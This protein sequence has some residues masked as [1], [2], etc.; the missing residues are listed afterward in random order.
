M[1]SFATGSE[2][3][4]QH[5]VTVVAVAWTIVAPSQYRM[6]GPFPHGMVQGWPMAER[7]GRFFLL[8]ELGVRRFPRSEHILFIC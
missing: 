5:G 8:P 2:G 6:N 4:G 3:A 1:I 7:R